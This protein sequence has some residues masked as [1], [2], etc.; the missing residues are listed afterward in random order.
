MILCVDVGNTRVKWARM[1]DGVLG[2]Q[3]AAVH[4]GWTVDQWRDALFGDG[5]VERVV[6]STVAGG[7]SADRLA[8]A[9]L[10]VTGRGVQFAATGREAAGVVNGYTE[11][12]LLG[13]DR[14]LAVVAAHHLAPEG[15]VVV[16]AGTAMTVDVVL[17]QGRHLG[18]YIVPGPDLMV[19][20]LMR[21][22]SDLAAHSETSPPS[23]VHGFADNT[24][25]A[26]G[27]GCR[28]ALAALID[29]AVEDATP[30]AGHPVELILT[31]GALEEIRP[32][33]VTPGRVVGDLVLRGLA[34]LAR[35]GEL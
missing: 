16:D 13:V 14:W 19:R 20:S 28:L 2:E 23:D 6:A 27:H 3:R 32:W 29:R 15:C 18:G 30:L 17:A 33:L 12:R 7:T 4:D 5:G 22:T 8:Q 25:D 11:P 10:A 31:G 34:R 1:R 26:I 24:R 35:S 21:G 9:A